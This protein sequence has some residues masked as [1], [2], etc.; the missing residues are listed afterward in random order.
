[1]A[2]WVHVFCPIHS[3]SLP[4]S[5]VLALVLTF[6]DS[7]GS[8]LHSPHRLIILSAYSSLL[9]GWARTLTPIVRLHLDFEISTATP[10]FAVARY[11]CSERGR[12]RRPETVIRQPGRHVLVAR[13]EHDL[14]IILATGTRIK[15]Q[16][17]GVGVLLPLVLFLALLLLR[18]DIRLLFLPARLRSL[19]SSP[20][21]STSSALF[22]PTSKHSI[23]RLGGF[24]VHNVN[25]P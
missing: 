14:A 3:E 15:L 25:N 6:I 16:H 17:A 9:L 24:F 20:P 8:A 2:Q 4:C 19:I 11:T 22:H 12:A 10:T 18:F 13:A 7:S 23:L 5:L 1:M 21:G